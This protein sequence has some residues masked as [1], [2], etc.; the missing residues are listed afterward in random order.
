MSGVVS[1]LVWLEL[2]PLT[3][4]GLPG[5]SDID[6]GKGAILSNAFHIFF[7]RSKRFLHH[8]CLKLDGKK[9]E[10]F[11]SASQVTERRRR[12]DACVSLAADGGEFG[13]FKFSFSSSLFFSLAHTPL[14]ILAS[15]G[16]HVIREHPSKRW[17]AHQY[18]LRI[19]R[20]L[21]IHAPVT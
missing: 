9:L 8:S 14:F 10:P 5:E 2:W 16:G 21:S 15:A 20:S 13:L 1:G 7:T 18:T 6:A 3:S 12:S 11:S 4:A 19:L 17:K